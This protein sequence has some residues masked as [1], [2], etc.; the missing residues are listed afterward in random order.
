[1]VQFLGDVAGGVLV[2]VVTAVLTVQLALRRFYTERWWE[3]KAEAYL[4]VIDALSVQLRQL[5]DELDELHSYQTQLQHSQTPGSVK[6]TVLPEEMRLENKRRW[7]EAVQELED[8]RIQGAF[9]LSD[10]SVGALERFQQERAMLARDVRY[11]GYDDILERQVELA[12]EVLDEFRSLAKKDLRVPR[13][14]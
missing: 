13:G 1:M 10:A 6:V 7:D 12:Q 9:L 2:A 4:N 14:R 5:Q 8:A 11:V 3:K